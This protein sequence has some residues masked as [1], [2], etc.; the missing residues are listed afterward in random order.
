MICGGMATPGWETCSPC[1]KEQM[2]EYY[3]S[4]GEEVY[5]DSLGIAWT[6][7]ELA[8]AGGMSEVEKMCNDNRAF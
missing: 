6:D 4:Q 2:M 3:E 5:I 8:E 1:D 7:D